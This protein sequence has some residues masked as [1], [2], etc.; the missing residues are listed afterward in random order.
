VTI[1]AQTDR[2]YLDV[3]AVQTLK[4][5][6]G[7]VEIESDAKCAVVWNCWTNDKNIADIGEG[8]HTGYLCV[9]RCDVAERAVTLAAGGGYRMSMTLSY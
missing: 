1:T 2:V 8:N 7:N 6:T 5:A 3:P 9:E 4:I